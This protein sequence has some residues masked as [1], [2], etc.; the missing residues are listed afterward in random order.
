MRYHWKLRSIHSEI[1]NYTDQK[2]PKQTLKVEIKSG[3]TPLYKPYSYVPLHRV[4]FLR[5]FGLKTG[6]VF[7]GT[8][9]VYER[10]YHFDSK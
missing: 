6:M 2:R 3:G 4:A 1:A 7:E 5:R 10:I 9:A 8:T